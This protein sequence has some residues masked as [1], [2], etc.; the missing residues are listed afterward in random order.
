MSEEI[1]MNVTPMEC[2]IALLENGV[3]QEVYIERT[4]S[5]GIVGNIYIG[6]ITR[7]LPG[8]Q[9]AFIDIG[10]ERTA[11]IHAN[12]IFQNTADEEKVINTPIQELIHEGQSLVVQVIK[13]PISSKGALLS[14]NISIPARYLVFMPNTKHIGISLKIED[15]EER[16]RLKTLISDYIATEEDSNQNNGFIVRTAAEGI[17]AEEIQK[18]IIFLRRL[19]KSI[20]ENIKGVTSVPANVYEEL[21]LELRVLR[22]FYN[23]KIERIRVDSLKSFNKLTNFATKLAPGVEKRITLHQGDQPIFDLFGVEDEIAKALNKKVPLKSGGYLI[24]EQTEAMTTIDVNT[25]AF[26][27]SRNLEETIYKTNLEATVAISRQLRLR[28]LGGIIVIDFIDMDN[29]EHQSQVLKILDKMLTNDPVKTFTSQ[30]S[31]LGLVEMTRKRTRESLQNMLCEPCKF[32]EGRGKIKTAETICYEIFRE[33]LRSAKA[34]NANKYMVLGS[35][36][37]IDRLL[38][39]ESNTVADLEDIVNKPIKF[40]VEPI[41]HQEQF[42]VIPL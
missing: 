41:Y 37:V 33:I 3:I 13:D 20:E 32:C 42:D 16:N 26:V 5:R 9:S 31:E 39:E 24:I 30:I 38:D 36:S 18:D 19:W 7:V 1:L 4:R 40:Q 22:D 2:R 29:K 8:M 34:Y 10:F 6:K 21:P 15:L 25:G 23:S 14:T 17:S 28:N 27:G 35:E 12:E 11:F